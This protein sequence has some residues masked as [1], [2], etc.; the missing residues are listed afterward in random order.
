MC[1]ISRTNF[2]NGGRNWKAHGKREGSSR[3]RRRHIINYVYNKNG[4]LTTSHL[5]SPAVHRLVAFHGAT[6]LAFGTR[7][8]RAQK[9]GCL[10]RISLNFTWI[11]GT[12][13][14]FCKTLN[15]LWWQKITYSASTPRLFVFFFQTQVFCRTPCPLP[16][17][18]S[19][20]Y[21]FISLIFTLKY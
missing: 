18:V 8:S 11:R 9:K 14:Y 5:Y 15:F 7:E 17:H 13:F 10:L 16:L 19:A 3:R 12:A 21:R 20:S 1:T 6:R 2:Q 4:W